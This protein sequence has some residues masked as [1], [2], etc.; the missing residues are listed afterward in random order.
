MIT[1]FKIF[2]NKSQF[3]TDEE[4]KELQ[5]L[6]RKISYHLDKYLGVDF[7]YCSW[8]DNKNTPVYLNIQLYKMIDNSKSDN[9]QNI[10]D[11]SAE[12][13]NRGKMDNILKAL[14]KCRKFGENSY[15]LTKEQAEQFLFEVKLK[16]IRFDAEKYNL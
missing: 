2:E 8:T 5:S 7:A 13:I 3:F 4:V 14:D 11:I 10:I 12:N 15:L 9:N 1:K 6:T 16:F